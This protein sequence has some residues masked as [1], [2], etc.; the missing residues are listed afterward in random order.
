MP[1]T[2]MLWIYITNTLQMGIF[3]V[4]LF[5]H[6]LIDLFYTLESE[7]SSRG[8]VRLIFLQSKAQDLNDTY[9]YCVCIKLYLKG[10]ILY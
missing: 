1:F 5:L 3:L 8:S 10:F 2:I 6:A 7:Q 9:C 4:P